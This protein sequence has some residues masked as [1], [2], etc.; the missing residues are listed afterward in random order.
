M[1]TEDD[2][3]KALDA[4]PADWQTRLVLADF[5]EERADVRAD[6]YRALGVLRRVPTSAFYRPGTSERWFLWFSA[7]RAAGLARNRSS[8]AQ[9]IAES[10]LLAALPA[11]WCAAI[12]ERAPA[13]ERGQWNHRGG[14]FGYGTSR[15][16]AEDAAALAF[17]ELPPAR[18]AELL[19]PGPG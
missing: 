17:A 14:W 19:A 18:R 9:D 2:F 10:M 4:D 8:P 11:D 1:T 5:L 3:Q 6:G 12:F 15:R 16:E 13:G 7:D